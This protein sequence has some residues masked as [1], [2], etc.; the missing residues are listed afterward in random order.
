MCSLHLTHPSAHT[1]SSGQPT[2]RRP[3]SSGGCS[4]LLK[5]ITSV[6]DNSCRSRDS[7]PQPRVTSPTLYS[8]EPRLP[9]THTH[10]HTHA[11]TRAHTHTHTEMFQL[12]LVYS[13][14]CIH[15]KVKS[16]EQFF[17]Q[18]NGKSL[19]NS[20]ISHVLNKHLLVKS[21]P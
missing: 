12:I 19:R 20:A 11:R 3:G 17:V 7:N 2:L 13:E 14:Y 15:F 16:A 6:V 4:A 8:L 21:F 5:G 1:P 10:T 18:I 9:H